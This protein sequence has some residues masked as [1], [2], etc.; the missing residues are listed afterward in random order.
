MQ[1]IFWSR[2]VSL[3][4]GGPHHTDWMRWTSIIFG[5]VLRIIIF[6][7]AKS[8][9]ITTISVWFGLVRFGERWFVPKDAPRSRML[10]LS[11]A[12]LLSR[13]CNRT[14]CV[15][16]AQRN[17]L[18]IWFYCC[19]SLNASHQFS[20]RNAWNTN[21]TRSPS[22]LS[23]RSERQRQSYICFGLRSPCS[24]AICSNL[25][26]ENNYQVDDNLIV[27]HCANTRTYKSTQIL[28]MKLLNGKY[29]IYKCERN[30]TKTQSLSFNEKLRYRYLARRSIML[31][32]RCD[33]CTERWF[34]FFDAY[35]LI[36]H[37]ESRK[38]TLC[39]TQIY[40]F[41]SNSWTIE[42][43]LMFINFL[44]YISLIAGCQRVHRNN[45]SQMRT[46]KYI[47]GNG[48]EVP[49][50]TQVRCAASC[51]AFRATWIDSA[52]R[53]IVHAG[54]D[55]RSV[56]NRIGNRQIH[57]FGKKH[58]QFCCFLSKTKFTECGSALR[59]IKQRCGD[60]K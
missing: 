2:L 50:S 18:W 32:L 56:A 21:D 14:N 6:H 54:S 22:L 7:R 46:Q 30:T 40:S 23:W 47:A 27:A 4:V 29:F 60:D 49:V 12:L 28:W 58:T 51:C 42:L 15:Y 13:Q 9:I 11:S 37:L 16:E 43:P 17:G 57:N 20:P 38:H 19:L 52:T 53:R 36:D 35:W 48:I 39:H 1:F 44:F 45:Q 8:F 41:Y 55:D 33:M 31:T 59:T 10:Y 3:S 5:F 34:H 26:L 24:H 25:Q